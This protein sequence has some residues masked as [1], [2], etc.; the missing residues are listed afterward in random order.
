MKNIAIIM[1]GYSSEYKISLISGNVV[2]QFLDKT[3]YNAFRIHI[4]KEK[5][6]Y[7]DASDT[8]FAIDKNDFSVT[9][10]G[11]K[12]TFDCVFNAIHGT[13]GEDG[14]MQAYFELLNI[15]QTS[16]D[17]Y[18]AALTF[19]KRDLLSVLKPYGIKTATSYYL[20]KGDKIN[21]DE[22]VAKVGLPCFVKPNKAGSSFG[23][24]KAKTAA[25]L[26]I[27][28]EVAY[29]EDNE[30]IIESFLDGTEVSVGV[31][32]YKGIVTVLPIT[33]IVS[34]NDFFDYEAKYLGKSQEITPARISDEMTQKVGEIAKRAYEILKMK[35]FSRSE[36]II[37]DGE[38]FMLEMNT[39]PGL[40]TESL[41]PQQAKAAGISLEDL[42][43][44][45][46]ELALNN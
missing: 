25:E 2:Y 10:A 27:A 46:I 42:F 16:C 43:T 31:I 45:A 40:T 4:F 15:P 14:L 17:Y 34:D 11:T 38:P 26:P 1:G 30:I 18:Q 7:V 20:N 24:S 3:Q 21:T 29:K 8:E 22:I 9:V 41:I 32:N 28:I 39:I 13:P 19:N 36:F 37:V 35:G 6:V 12:I 5:W 44:N 33:E 23:I